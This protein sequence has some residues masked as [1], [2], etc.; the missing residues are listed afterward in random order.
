M[1]AAILI[2]LLGNIT[3]L[4]ENIIIQM[5]LTC[6]AYQAGK[7]RCV[8]ALLQAESR[9]QKRRLAIHNPKRKKRKYW[10]RP[11]RTLLWWE[12]FVN[13]IVV[14]EEWRENFQMSK[15][16]F[17]K[18]F[19]KVRPFL[20]KQSTNMRSPI[21]VEK[22]VAVTLY[23]LSDKGRYLKVANA[24]GIGKS[25]VSETVRR[26]CKCISIVLGPEYIKLPTSEQDV[27]QAVSNFYDAHGFPQCIGAVDGTHIFIKQPLENAT[28][29]V[30]R[31]NRYSLNVQAI[32]DYRSCFMDVVIKWPGSVHDARIFCN[33]KL[34]EML[35]NG[36]IPSL[37]KVIVPNTDPV[38]IC[39]LGDPA[40]PLLP[41]VMKEYPGGGSTSEEQFFGWRLC[42]ARMVIECAFGRLKGRFG[43]LRRE[44][45]I[46][47]NNL[48]DVIHA[49]FIL[50]NYCEMNGES[51]ANESVGKAISYEREFQPAAPNAKNQGSTARSKQ[52]RKVFVEYFN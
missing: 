35:R 8:I 37:P 16:N 22:Q 10:V 48:P 31:K 14:A 25:T 1:E 33:S 44:M 15:E 42:S 24:F 18:L 7:R 34:N 19:D 26:V 46:N 17:M 28:D 29:F 50:H 9:I 51:I 43:A 12:N 6:T 32:C 45:D 23:Y 30:N 3:A 40:Y 2:T 39:V 20:L 36:S 41:Y 27:K 47:L 38:P 21:S 52:I 4:M 11:G 13:N 5:A 49:S